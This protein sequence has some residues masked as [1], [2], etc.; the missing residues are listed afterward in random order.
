[1]RARLL[2]LGTLKFVLNLPCCHCW[3]T[4]LLAQCAWIPSMADEASTGAAQLM[5][6]GQISFARSQIHPKGM[7]YKE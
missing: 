2:A 6:L 3:Q 1:M 4:L 5:L 7:A